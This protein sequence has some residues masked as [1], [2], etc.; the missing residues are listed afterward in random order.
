M[1]RMVAGA[2]A[3]EDSPI[4]Q[5]HGMEVRFARVLAEVELPDGAVAVE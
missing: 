2:E 5:G 4:K 1:P 3:S